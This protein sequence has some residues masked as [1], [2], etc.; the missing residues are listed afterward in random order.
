MSHVVFSR[1]L[2]CPSPAHPELSWFCPEV[3]R[4]SSAFSGKG[5]FGAVRRPG[6]RWTLQSTLQ[7]FLPGSDRDRLPVDNVRSC[8]GSSVLNMQQGHPTYVILLG[9]FNSPL[10][11]SFK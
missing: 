2:A 9:P 4:A 11:P 7:L 10:I 3:G 6:F 8:C 5:S 1:R